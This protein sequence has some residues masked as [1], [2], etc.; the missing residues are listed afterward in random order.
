MTYRTQDGQQ[1]VVSNVGELVSQ[2]RQDSWLGTAG[3]KAAWRKAAALRAAQSGAA[4]RAD[5]DAHFV[6]DLINAGL[7]E[8]IAK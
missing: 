5:S 4:V 7:I 1:Y 6:K 3:S 8:E 2:L